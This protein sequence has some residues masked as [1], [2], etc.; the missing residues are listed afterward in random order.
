MNRNNKKVI[1]AMSGGVDSSVTAFMLQNSGYEVIGVFMRLGVDQGFAEDSAR[2]VCQKL[3]I[4]FYP[5]NVAPNFRK[6][7]VDYFLKSYAKGLTPNPCIQCNKF[8]KF[9]ELLKLADQLGAE[10]LATGHYVIKQETQNIEQKY[11]LFKGK[12]ETKDQSYFLYNLTQKQLERILFPL[13]NYK[14]EEVKKIAKKNNLPVQESE[15]Q[16]ICFL[17]GGHNDFLKDKISLKPGKIVALNGE[18]LGKHQGLPLYTIGQRRGVEIGGTGPYYVVKI[19]YK[20]NILYV[21]KDRDDP[22][23]YAKKIKLSKTNW[24]SGEKPEF[25]FQCQAVIRY[26]HQPAACEVYQEKNSKLSVDFS[27]PQRAIAPGQSVVFYKGKEVLGGGVI[28]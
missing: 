11:K 18:E 25:P 12:D 3:S 24:I 22:A 1:V 17:S 14:K 23:L 2:R 4:K 7:V 15:S 13:G 8:I 21:S 5:F 26:R 6:E 20:K 16:D 9:G 28:I 27:Q 19:D 10:Y